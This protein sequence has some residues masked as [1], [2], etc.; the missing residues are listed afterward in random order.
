MNWESR[1]HRNKE[2][3]RS[4]EAA[5]NR[6][7]QQFRQKAQLDKGS[8]R[9]ILRKFWRLEW[10]IKAAMLMASG[11]V[12]YTAFRYPHRFDRPLYYLQHGGIYAALTAVPITAGLY[13][14]GIWRWLQYKIGFGLYYMSMI[15]LGGGVAMARV[16]GLTNGPEYLKWAL[17]GSWIFGVTGM[18]VGAI[19]WVRRRAAKRRA[20]VAEAASA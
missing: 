17:I 10:Q 18:V 11:G 19:R 15:G 1:Q 7:M 12:G 3:I 4:S 6:R 9:S 8:Y 2:A 16:H 14:F 5:E 13:G 20:T